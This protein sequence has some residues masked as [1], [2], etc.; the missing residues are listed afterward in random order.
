MQASSVSI[1]RQNLEGLLAMFTIGVGLW[2]IA[3]TGAIVMYQKDL[4]ASGVLYLLSP[5]YLCD[6]DGLA[7]S[8]LSARTFC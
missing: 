7:V 5:E 6:D 3:V 8:V 4:L 1:R 2:L